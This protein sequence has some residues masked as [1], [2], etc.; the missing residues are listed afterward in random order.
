MKSFRYDRL[1]LLEV[2]YSCMLGKLCTIFP[3]MLLESHRNCK[4]S[5]I[6]I[7]YL[8]AYM[9]ESCTAITYMIKSLF[10]TWM[11]IGFFMCRFDNFKNLITGYNSSAFSKYGIRI[12][13]HTY[14]W[15]NKITHKILTSWTLLSCIHKIKQRVRVTFLRQPFYD[16]T[17]TCFS[18]KAG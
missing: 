14:I 3:H 16:V 6:I 12:N 9:S 4:Q 11:C 7:S 8:L 13:L 17:K 1:S 5:T 18:P 2:F 10:Q 15:G